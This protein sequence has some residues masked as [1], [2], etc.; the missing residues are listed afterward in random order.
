MRTKEPIQVVCDGC[1]RAGAG[2]RVSN[3]VHLAEGPVNLQT[4][5][6]PAGWKTA[7]VRPDISLPGGQSVDANMTAPALARATNG[8]VEACLCDRCQK[9]LERMPVNAKA[10]DVEPLAEPE[11]TEESAVASLEAQRAA[12]RTLQ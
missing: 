3:T 2:F 1:N 12:A 9:K 7:L 4:I 5:Q 10:S 6:P 11:P 8:S